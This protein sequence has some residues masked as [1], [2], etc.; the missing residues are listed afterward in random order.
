MVPTETRSDE[1]STTFFRSYARKL[2]S[3]TRTVYRPGGRLVT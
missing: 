3:S 2:A 1:L